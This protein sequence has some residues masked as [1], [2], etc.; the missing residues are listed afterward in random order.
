MSVFGQSNDGGGSYTKRKYFDLKDGESVYRILPAM[1]EDQNTGTWSVFWKVHFGYKNSEGKL[2]LFHSPE[3]KNNKT[4]MIDVP[5]AALNRITKLKAQFEE[6]KKGN[7]SELIAKLDKLVGQ[8]GQF[9]MSSHHYLNAMDTQGNIGLL[10]IRHRCKSAL[11]TVITKLKE[12]GVDPRS[13]V[14]GRY[15]IFTRSGSGL[16]TQF[17]VDVLKKTIQLPDG[18]TAEQDVVHSLTADIGDRCVRME[19]GKWKYYE[20]TNLRTVYAEPTSEQVARIVAEGAK[21]VDEILD[22]KK[23]SQS[24]EADSDESDYQEAKITPAQ[25]SAPQVVIQPVA[26]VA[27][28]APAPVVVAPV[29]SASPFQAAAPI[30]ATP[31]PTQT[32]TT[33]Q[34]VESQSDDDFLRS[35]GA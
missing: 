8:R 6:A 19:N 28:A 14:N 9:N 34:V 7:D 16:D 23:G 1:G 25:A 32:K 33:A 24:H 10:K 3:V 2:R 5:D 13:P 31:A 22:T 29:Q 26:Q 35:L 4:K 30:V 27:V 21:A 17:K 12:K 18:S 11:E 20:A 15:L